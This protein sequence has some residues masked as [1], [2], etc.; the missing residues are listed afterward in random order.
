MLVT[1]SALRRFL[2]RSRF[3]ES[4]G[5]HRNRRSRNFEGLQRSHLTVETLDKER[6]LLRSIDLAQKP[7]TD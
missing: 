6:R 4:G 1:A 2:A 5:P 3:Q 7:D